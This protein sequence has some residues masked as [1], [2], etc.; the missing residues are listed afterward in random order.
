MWLG[1]GREQLVDEFME[2]A[3]L[4]TAGVLVPEIN[5]E[6]HRGSRQGGSD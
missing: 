5:L 4:R 3:R 2:S 6:D 1:L